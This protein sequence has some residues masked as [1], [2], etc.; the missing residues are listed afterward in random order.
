QRRFGRAA[1]PV[2][3]AMMHGIFAGDA[4]ALEVAATLPAA[5]AMEREYGSLLKGM[6]ARARA[7]R[8]RG[9]QARP[10]VCTFRRGMAGSVDALA[11]AL[12]D[13]VVTRARVDSVAR[14]P[15]GYA[16]RGE[17][18][19][20]HAPEVCVTAPPQAAGQMLR[21]LDAALADCLAEIP[22]VAVA[23]CYLGFDHAAVPPDV[24]G[25]GFLAPQGELGSVLGAI[26][27]SSVFP[28]QAP[29]GSALFRVMSGGHAYPHEVERSDEQL[30]EQASDVLRDLL[31]IYQRPT[32]RY[33]SRAR[34]AIPQYVHGHSA[35]MQAAA[36][37]LEQHPGLKLRGA[38]YRKVSVV[39]QWTQE[40]SAP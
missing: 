29:E 9:E 38:G 15:S 40:G 22:T 30:L 6:G 35:R 31:G 20:L 1:V 12:G 36:A 32:F 21:G 7:R 13:A 34:A 10:A 27:T 26:Y 39:G 14:A 2:A 4:H 23:S 37:K 25:F 24:D 5:A 8:E 11:G 19:E 17:G 33:V 18:I 28:H 3:E 16:V